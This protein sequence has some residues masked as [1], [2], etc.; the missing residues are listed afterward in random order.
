[1]KWVGGKRQLLPELAK[2]VPE[3]FGTYFEPFIGG[4]AFFL[5]LHPAKA[6]INDFNP[7]LI[8]AWK[9]VKEFPEELLTKL[10]EHASKNTKEYYLDIRLT[11]RDGRLEN[12]TEIERA[13]RF[14]YMLK[15]GF[16]GL[17]RM[18]KK[19]QNNV[20]YGSYK[21]PNIA[22]TQTIRQVS[23]FL[24]SIQLEMRSGDFSKA[25]AGVS[26]GDFVYFDPPY[27][28]LT[29]TSSFT[30][31]SAEFGYAE[32]LRLRDLV[33][34][35]HQSGVYVTLS[36]SDVPQIY[37]LYGD[38]PGIH[39]HQVTAQR[40]VGAKANSRGKVGEVIVT[41]VG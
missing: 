40:S 4:G 25:V 26:T 33:K 34:T 24:N 37:E 17:W 31:Y 21:N 18:N 38:I 35:L 6:V 2:Y 27:I 8:N 30:S 14:I 7:E 13:A 36:N 28:P 5:A 19:G 41:N 22:D 1:M 29:E 15:T 39:I 10:A 32:Q 9:I 16:N 20:P 12:M 11:D 23:T 3:K